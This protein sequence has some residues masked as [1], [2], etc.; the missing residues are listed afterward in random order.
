MQHVELLHEQP[1]LDASGIGVLLL[2]PRV[3]K[4][5]PLLLTVACKWESSAADEPGRAVP[6]GNA[7]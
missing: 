6:P 4:D 2:Q 3:R 1:Q 7:A 5:K